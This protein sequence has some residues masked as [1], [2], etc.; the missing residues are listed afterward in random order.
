MSSGIQRNSQCSKIVSKILKQKPPIHFNKKEDLIIM[1]RANG[2]KKSD[3]KSI[4]YLG[5]RIT[6]FTNTGERF[7]ICPTN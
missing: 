2:V 4:E 3:V 6:G 7:V 1:L 5:D